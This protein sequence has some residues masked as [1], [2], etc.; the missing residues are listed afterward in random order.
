MEKLTLR[1]IAVGA[2]LIASGALVN[3]LGKQDRTTRTEVWVEGKL[4]QSVGKFTMVTGEQPGSTYRM[5]E[6]TYETLKPYGIVCRRYTK[7]S[8]MYD[9]V[10]IASRSK[11][12][13]HDPAQ[14]FTSQGF[15]LE[16]SSEL[17][18]ET[19][20]HGPMMSTLREMVREGRPMIT[21]YFY[22][23]PTGYTAKNSEVKWTLLFEQMKLNTDLDSAFYRFIPLHDGATKEQ[24]AKFMGEYMDATAKSS[25]QIF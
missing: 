12:S 11:E 8:E 20:T 21:A 16:G 4:P 2:V 14:C 15:V 24:L 17:P 3:A 5:D 25:D 18:F 1:I 6:S 13:F 22:K 19:K 7:G 23:S 9:V 10:V